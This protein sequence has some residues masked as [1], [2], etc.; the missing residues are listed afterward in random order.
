MLMQ[1][2]DGDMFMIK[3]TSLQTKPDVDRLEGKRQVVKLQNR[4]RSKH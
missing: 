1:L 3:K 2:N 4:L